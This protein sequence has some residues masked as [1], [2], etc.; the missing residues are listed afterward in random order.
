MAEFT[1]ITIES[2]EQLDGMFKDRLNRQNEKHSKEISELKA[3]ITEFETLKEKESGYVS[4]IEELNKQ[5]TE[6]GD[7]ANSYD[8]Q[9]A[10]KDNLIKN[11]T[12]NSLKEKAVRNFDLSSEAIEFLH[13]ETEEEINASAEKLQKLAPKQKVAPLVGDNSKEVDGV[14]A[15]FRAMNPH[16]KI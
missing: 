5:L 3:Q 2:Q 1:P 12:I 13:G 16:I 11:L 6:L 15:S 14:L 7:K 8:S 10:E 4:Q 9:I